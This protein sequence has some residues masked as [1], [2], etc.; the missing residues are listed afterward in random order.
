[1]Q[2]A[3]VIQATSLGHFVVI[4]QQA[5]L[6]LFV[7]SDVNF[8]DASLARTVEVHVKIILMT[9]AAYIE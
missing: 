9:F 1:M 4:M 6:V 3:M 7:E 5:G 8:M 2:T